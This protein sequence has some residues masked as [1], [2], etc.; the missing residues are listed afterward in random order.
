MLQLGE[1]QCEFLEFSFQPE[2]KGGEFLLE[3]HWE[4][5]FRNIGAIY[6]E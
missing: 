3:E 4:A 5:I 1:F 6:D 2:R